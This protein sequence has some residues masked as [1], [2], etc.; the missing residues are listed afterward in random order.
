MK[1]LEE[2]EHWMGRLANALGAHAR[3]EHIE[4]LSRLCE[5][6]ADKVRRDKDAPP[7]ELPQRIRLSTDWIQLQRRA[8]QVTQQ[9]AP[10]RTVGGLRVFDGGKLCRK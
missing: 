7:S 2:L 6:F 5:L 9:P 1:A 8:Q 3:R 10:V 4:P